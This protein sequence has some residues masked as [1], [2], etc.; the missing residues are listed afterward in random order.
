MNTLL[1]MVLVVMAVPSLFPRNGVVVEFLVAA[2]RGLEAGRQS[3]K[4]KMMTS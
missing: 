4:R 2:R 1:K 3:K